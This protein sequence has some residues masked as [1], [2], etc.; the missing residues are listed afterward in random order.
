M[1]VTEVET[2][3][4]MSEKESF[5]TSLPKKQKEKEEKC[6]VIR[7]NPKEKTLDVMFKGYGIRIYN[8]ESFHGETATVKYKGEIGTKDFSYKL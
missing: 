5:T 7:Y 1:T 6:K 2:K 3:D 4:D 8:V